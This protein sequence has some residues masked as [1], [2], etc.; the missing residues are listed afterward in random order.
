MLKT[1]T[2]ESEEKTSNIEKKKNYD[3]LLYR[4]AGNYRT[5]CSRQNLIQNFFG[6][7]NFFEPNETN[8]TDNGKSLPGKSIEYF[9]F[10][11][12]F[13]SKLLFLENRR[14]LEG[15]KL[16]K[17][18]LLNFGFSNVSIGKKENNLSVNSNRYPKDLCFDTEDIRPR[19]FVWIFK[20][21]SGKQ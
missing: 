6:E 19:N 5:T 15:K 12:F 3:L 20:S 1:Q 4:S 11:I 8:I 13:L 16:W 18:E 17:V 10:K 7:K 9:N 21:N 14:L 2:L